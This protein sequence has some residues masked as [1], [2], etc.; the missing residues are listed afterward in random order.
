MPPVSSG[1]SVSPATSLP[2]N[3]IVALDAVSLSHAI[4][5]RTVSCVE[6]MQAYLAQG[7]RL[8]PKVNAIVCHEDPQSLLTQ[9]GERDAQLAR[10]QSQGWMHGFPQAPKDIAPVAGMITTQ[11]SPILREQRLPTDAAVV[12]RARASG[13]IFIG[14]TNTPEFGFGAHTFN[15]VY[16]TTLNAFDQR[17]SAG[18]S[19]GGAAVAVALNLLPVAD[20]SDQ[21]GSLRVPAAFNNIFGMRPSLG[22]VPRAPVAE[23][24]FQ[25]L[26]TEGPMARTVA[27]LA[28]LLSVQAGYD[29]RAPQS[30]RQDP[31]VFAQP[32]SRDWKG[33][34]IGWLGD[35]NGY[36]ATEPGIMALSQEALRHFDT[37]GC[38]VEAVQPDFS[39]T[40]LWDAWLTLRSWTAAGGLVHLY[41]DPALRAQI[42]PEAIWEIERGLAMDALSVYKAS[43]DRS[44]W[45]QALG[46]LFETYDFLVLPTTQVF[47]FDATLRWPAAIDGREMDTYHRWMEI[48]ITA[49]VAGLPALSVPAGFN[50]QGLPGGL[51]IV[52]R[53]QADLSVLQLGHAYEHASGY[54][55]VRSPLLG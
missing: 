35:F 11:G 27:D 53:P 15:P 29:V 52:G 1:A 8:N 12:A 50:A 13:S 23:T 5:S 4:H 19:S 14:R 46:K 45:Y 6:V 25:Q 24:F 30:T 21:M 37:I 51:Q 33:A 22:C 48:V 18:G 9:A 44:A 17:L 7:E 39:L 2:G 32:L 20:G 54:S 49:T 3:D 31:T 28:M 40:R 26:S 41:N 47:P 42:K 16:G 34:R 38:T 36:L 55:R 10:G 43:A